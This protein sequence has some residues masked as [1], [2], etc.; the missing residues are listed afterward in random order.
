MKEL[1]LILTGA[2]I[3]GI[4]TIIGTIITCFLSMKIAKRQEYNKAAAKFRSEFINTLH[5]TIQ[6]PDSSLT[7]ILS[8]AS[9]RHEIAMLEF[10]HYLP[11]NELAIF[12][13]A[14]REFACPHKEI[15]DIMDYDAYQYHANE[16]NE[17]KRMLLLARQRIEKL[18][19]CA[20]PK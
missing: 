2:F 5:N 3:A 15:P 20:K 4:F 16:I 9:S 12:D 18:L 19:E 13:T 8:Q 14:W 6:Q 1:F 10:R 17:Q 11:G 7:A